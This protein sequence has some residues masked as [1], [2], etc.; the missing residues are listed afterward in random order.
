[1]MLLLLLFARKQGALCWL[2]WQREAG[3][4]EDR[5]HLSG[6][7]ANIMVHIMLHGMLPDVLRRRNSRGHPTP[8]LSHT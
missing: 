4:K 2:N 6:G 1:M 5:D 7:G 3:H 8:R